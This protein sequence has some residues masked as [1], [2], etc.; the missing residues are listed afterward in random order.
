MAF[1]TLYT[2]WFGELNDNS[3][4]FFLLEHADTMKRY[5]SRAMK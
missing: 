5:A 1:D 4:A 2:K 3:R